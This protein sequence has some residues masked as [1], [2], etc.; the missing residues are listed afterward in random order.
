[1][2]PSNR[3]PRRTAFTLIELLVVI[4]IIALLIGILLPALGAARE[5]ARLSACLSNTRQLNIGAQAYATENKDFLPYL[6]RGDSDDIPRGIITFDDLLSEYVGNRRPRDIQELYELGANPFN[7]LEAY[8]DDILVCPSDQVERRPGRPEDFGVRSYLMVTGASGNDS[9]VNG[10]T[11]QPTFDT[12]D[13]PMQFYGAVGATFG[14]GD[15]ATYQGNLATDIPDASGTLL[16]SEQHGLWNTPGGI[17]GAFSWLIN[18]AWQYYDELNG[19]ATAGNINSLPHGSRSGDINDPLQDVDGIFSYAYADGHSEAKSANE[20][21][22]SANVTLTRGYQNV[23][24]E[25][26][27]DPKD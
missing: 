5:S 7:G 18:P 21:Y 4:S 19:N 27:R 13:G 22:D 3:L 14:R 12:V 17:N 9:P 1:M 6:S 15:I 26:T 8:H 11:M 23:G 2:L 24:G 10:G 16:I 25:W 20:T